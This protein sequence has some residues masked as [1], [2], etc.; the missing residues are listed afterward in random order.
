MPKS[1]ITFWT[2]KFAANEQRDAAA[3]LELRAL[4]WR[5][6]I[7]WECETKNPGLLIRRLSGEI[8]AE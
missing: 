5:V 8:A 3:I 4:G 2:K 1:N 7:V 6:V